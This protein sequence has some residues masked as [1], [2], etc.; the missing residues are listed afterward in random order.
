MDYGNDGRAGLAIGRF[1]AVLTPKEPLYV[2]AGTVDGVVLLEPTLTA[3]SQETQYGTVR[4]TFHAGRWN[5]EVSAENRTFV[6]R[7]LPGSF[8]AGRTVVVGSEEEQALR[9]NA[10]E[11]FVESL[12]DQHARQRR[13][14]GAAAE[15]RADKARDHS[16]RR[17]LR[18]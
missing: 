3:E 1:E 18:H 10:H 9:D 17:L 7:G 15:D 2:E 14:D 12:K 16:T 8:Y 11:R 4:A 13:D 5:T 6:G